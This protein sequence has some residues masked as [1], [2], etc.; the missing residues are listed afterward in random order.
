MTERVDKAPQGEVQRT[1]QA[2]K[3]QG[4][5]AHAEAAVLS[6]PPPP[7]AARLTPTTM[8]RL[9]RSLGNAQ[10]QRLLVQHSAASPVERRIQR[11]AADELIDRYTRLLDLKEDELGAELARRAQSGSLAIVTQVLDAL[12]STDRDDVAYE[13]MVRVDDSLLVRLVGTAEGRRLLDRIYDELSSGGFADEERLQANR[14]VTAREAG[15]A[16]AARAQSLEELKI[17]PFKLPG[18]T[19]LSDAP[20]SAERRGG[21]RIWVKLPV[22]VLGTER[23]RAETRTLPSQA[24]TSGIELPE[25]EMIGVRMY[26]AGGELHVRPALYLVQL[27]NETDTRILEAMGEAAGIGLTLGS[28]ALAGLGI[29]A[30]M[31]ARVLLWADRAA[32]TIGLIT[33]TLRDHRGWILERF[34]A[35]GR[36]FLD[37][38]DFTHRVVA[39]YGMARAVFELGRVISG[40]RSASASW[41]RAVGEAEGELS[42][43]QQRAAQE[44]QGQAD[45]FFARADDIQGAGSRPPGD[46]PEGAPAAGA[47]GGRPPRDLAATD[48]PAP[49]GPRPDEP[50]APPTGPVTLSVETGRQMVARLRAAGEEV[51]VNIG[52][53][54]ARH[55]PPHAINLNPNRVASRSGIPNHIADAGENI[56]SHFDAGSIDQVV[57]HHL[58][59]TVLDW[60]QI[61]PGAYTVLRAGG[62]FEIYFRGAHPGDA[63]RLAAALREAGFQQVRV[64]SDVLIQARKP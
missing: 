11:T 63:A 29:R 47:G 1:P 6:Q 60:D 21:G 28:G 14:I 35:T 4:V 24:F 15:I 31:A 42:A 8:R 52:G 22:R 12:G 19:V 41:R 40:F 46:T 37:Y 64:T 7:R 49:S 51:I 48:G 58:P 10:V 36:R 27:A 50:A 23:F 44:I 9:Q 56:A 62:R 32:F 18:I 38:V 57:G 33:T 59:P 16:P 34:G 25:N 17:F 5:G 61:A 55:E 53:A 2:S 26:D 13:L 30:S 43:A 39:V 45:E 20:I 54:G 3:G